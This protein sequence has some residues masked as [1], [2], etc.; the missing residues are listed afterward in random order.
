MGLLNTLSCCCLREVCLLWIKVSISVY[1]E[2]FHLNVLILAQ[3]FLRYS[4]AF[5]V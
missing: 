2:V 4:V 3:M 1:S 5:P